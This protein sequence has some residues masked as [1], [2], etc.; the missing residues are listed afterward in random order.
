[1][2]NGIPM[3]IGL[4]IFIS[5]YFS[6]SAY[7]DQKKMYKDLYQEYNT[8]CSSRHE[9]PTKYAYLKDTETH[10]F[11]RDRYFADKLD[12]E[13]EGICEPKIT[14]DQCKRGISE[15]SFKKHLFGYLGIEFMDIQYVVN[16]NNKLYYPDIF[17]KIKVGS[18]TAYID[19]EIDEPYSLSL[20]PIHYIG[21]DNL[22]NNCFKKN[23]WIVVRFAEEQIVSF[24][25]ECSEL[26]LSITTYLN[27][28]GT[29]KISDC[30]NI[31]IPQWTLNESRQMMRN[32]YRYSYLPYVKI[33]RDSA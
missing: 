9:A 12:K 18:N 27:S 10:Y 15:L 22:R 19:I 8:Y 13:L 26:I 33:I 4:I 31:K 21:S 6:I 7:R 17:I 11:Y 29:E 16:F 3:I 25:D 1:M 24:P 32:N 20:E 14:Q 30:K 2:G 5:Q 23:N 28:G